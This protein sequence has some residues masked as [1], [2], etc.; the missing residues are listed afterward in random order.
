MARQFTPVGALGAGIGWFELWRERRWLAAT[1][2]AAFVGFSVYAMGHDTVDSL[3]YLVPALPL[4][5]LWLGAGVDGATEWLRAHVGGNRER[6][7]GGI[8]VALLFLVP[9]LQTL[10][11]WGAM[12]LSGDRSAMAWAERTLEEAPANGVLVTESDAHTFTLWYAVKVLGM[13]SDVVVI[14]TDLWYRAPYRE[15]IAD[16]LD[17]ADVGPALTAFEAGQRTGRPVVSLPK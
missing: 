5:A 12:D 6:V 9:L 15:Q 16:E 14:D 1:S 8:S 4:A 11:L 17:V 3:V 13:R 2:L 10:F 7:A